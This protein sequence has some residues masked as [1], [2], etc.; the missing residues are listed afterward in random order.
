MYTHTQTNLS[1]QKIIIII[2]ERKLKFINQ[3]NTHTH[4]RKYNWF[5]A[6]N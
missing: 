1:T 2:K 4:A 6:V 3:R 5:T